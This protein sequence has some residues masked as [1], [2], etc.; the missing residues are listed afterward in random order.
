MPALL[1]RLVIDTNTLL[2][3]MLNMQSLSGLVVNACDQRR[4]LVVLSKPVLTEYRNVLTDPEIVERYPELTARKVEVA[5]RR[6]A[7]VGDV[8]RSG[9]C[10]FAFPRDPKDAKFIEL[11]IAGDATHIITLDHDLLSLR[12]D[13]ADAGKRF[14]QRLPGVSVVQPGEFIRLYGREIGIE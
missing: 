13:H 10:Q 14:R 8:V 9:A 12:T 1:H 4:A 5:L 11:A 6:L 7:Y 3:A 2:R